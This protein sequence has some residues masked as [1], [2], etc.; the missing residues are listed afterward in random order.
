MSQFVTSNLFLILLAI[1]LRA[2]SGYADEPKPEVAVEKLIELAEDG[3][4]KA[5]LRLG[6]VLFSG[7]GNVTPDPLQAVYWFTQAAKQ[8]E[9]GANYR[10]AQCYE[11]GLGVDRDLAS[12]V[13]LYSTAAANGIKAANVRIGIL[14]TKLGRV[15]EAAGYLRQAAEDGDLE[16][17]REY[18]K[19]LLHGAG[20]QEDSRRA[21]KY[22]EL[23]AAAG[24]G[25][26]HMILADCYSGVYKGVESDPSKMIGYLWEA[27]SSLNSAAAQSKLA[28]C[29]EEGV[30]VTKIPDS[31]MS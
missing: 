10:L 24:D 14:L 1:F 15:E 19:L 11:V 13:E 30:G 21:I 20:S 8:G 25:E 23:A 5:Q 9:V 7:F 3:D 2:D 31:G 18:A 28:F 6:T 12:A 26:A 29:Y 4:S 16:S 22:L 17:S 27:S